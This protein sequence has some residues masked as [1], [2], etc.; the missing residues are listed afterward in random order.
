MKK[1]LDKITLNKIPKIELHCHL[2]GSLRAKSVISEAEKNGIVLSEEVIDNIEKYLIAP[3]SCSSLLEYLDRFEIPIKVMQTSSSIERF[4]FEVFEDAYRENVSY[5]ELRFAP[6]LHTAKNLSQEEAIKSVING[7]KKAQSKYPIYGNI[8]LCCMRTLTEEDAIHT[9]EAGKKYLGRGV[10]GID[11]A[12]PEEEGFP[13]K[14][15]NAMLLAK[16]YGYNITIH[17]GEAGS[18]KNILDSIKQLNATRI[19]HGVSAHKRKNIEEIIKNNNIMIEVCPTSNLQ[20]KA[21]ESLESHPVLDFIK[22]DIKVSINTDNRTV[23]NTNLTSEYAKMSFLMN[24]D[25]DMYKKIYYDSVMSSF[26]D[27]DTKK[28]LMEKF[29]DFLDKF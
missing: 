21:V 6:V 13:S 20:T 28:I 19:G 17:A 11:L 10:V 2:D 9:V 24:T 5:L 22:Q 25:I 27:V 29:E 7:M 14:Y 12:G 26:A 23:S 16:N 8:I 3:M 18:G 4:A 1:I 15:I